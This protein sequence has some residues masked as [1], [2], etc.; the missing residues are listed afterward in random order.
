MSDVAAA[1]GVSLV[2]V[3]R[4]IN[5]PDQVATETLALVRAAVERLGYVP[6]LMAGSLASKRS[7]IVAAIVPTISN[8][9]FSEMVEGLAAILNAQ[10][11]QLLLGQSSYR[12]EDEE[13]LIETFLGRR[14]DGLVLTGTPRLERL[15]ARLR[16]SGLPV[17]QTWELPARPID[18]A[19]GFS[20]FE[21]GAA[22]GRYLT[23]RGR[24]HIGF[25]GADEDR[26]AQRLAGLRATL[27]AAGMAPPEVEVA[28]PPVMID[29]AGPSLR[30]MLARQPNLDAVFCNND[31]LAAGVL[32]ECQR[33][34]ICVPEQMAVM[35]FGDLPIARAAHPALS[36]LRIGRRGMGEQAGRLLL[37]R[38][39][40]Q[41]AQVGVVDIGFEVIERESA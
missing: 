35:G 28:P 15:A 4:C 7:R 34:G 27:A 31:Q 26:A 36:T 20:N 11:Y 17:V 18:M 21:A 39:A 8:S 12:A 5:H 1:A 6:N 22:A 9:V 37:D 16:R 24:H 14:V 19:V 38:L 23:A 41:P 32:F 10:G 13:K 29:Q 2:T 40:G 3:S 33:L 25:L 30:A